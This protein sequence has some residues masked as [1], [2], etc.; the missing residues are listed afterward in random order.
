MYDKINNIF[1]NQKFKNTSSLYRKK[2][3]IALVFKHLLLIL[4]QIL[5]ISIKL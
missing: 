4:K 1:K 5:T 3:V 2:F